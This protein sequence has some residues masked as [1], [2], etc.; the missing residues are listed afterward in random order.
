MFEKKKAPPS[1]ILTASNRGLPNMNNFLKDGS[2]SRA[3]SRIS[4]NQG[5]ANIL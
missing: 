3:S 5:S 1:R 4:G 2:N